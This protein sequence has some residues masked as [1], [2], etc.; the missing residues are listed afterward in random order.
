MCS[1]GNRVL[2]ISLEFG[3][4]DSKAPQTRRKLETYFSRWGDNG[5]LTT[6]SDPEGKFVAADF[7]V[8]RIDSKI[9]GGFGSFSL[10]GSRAGIE[11]AQNPIRLLIRIECHPIK[12]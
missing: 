5:L 4:P 6:L 11:K 1:L 3:N 8:I 7:K 10:G 12:Q 2:R 9:G